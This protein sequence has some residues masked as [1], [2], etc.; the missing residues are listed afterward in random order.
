MMTMGSLNPAPIFR[1]INKWSGTLIVDEADQ[2]A[3][4]KGQVTDEANAIIK[5]LNAGFEKNRPVIRCNQKDANILEFFDVF[6]PKVISRRQRFYDKAL[7]SRCF[8]H[9]MKVTARLDLPDTLTQSFFDEAEDIRQQLL[10]Y[11]LTNFDIVDPEAS[12]NIDLSQFDPR[13]RQL[14][15]Q[16][17][18]MFIEDKQQ[19]KEFKKFLGEVQANL[20]EER[21]ETFEG[22]IIDIMMSLIILGDKNITASKIRAEYPN[23]DRVYEAS[24]GRK[25]KELGFEVHLVKVPQHKKVMKVIKLDPYVFN[26]VIPRYCPDD[27]KIVEFFR[28]DKRVIYCFEDKSQTH[29][30]DVPWNYNR[31]CVC[32]CCYVSRRWRAI[33]DL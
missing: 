26:Q 6:C 17:M 7:E 22:R 31:R 28:P 32:D 21:S 19:I 10:Y 24:I 11:R 2:Q 9:I 13:L 1:I 8:T 15:R 33:F 20:V 16:F 25:L 5:I 3:N 27:D 23:N 18:G 14:N 12:V 4:N 29:V 30:F